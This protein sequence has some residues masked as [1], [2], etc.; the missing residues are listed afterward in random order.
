MCLLLYCRFKS[1]NAEKER[2]CLLFV[3]LF[4]S[5]PKPNVY[6][7]S[8]SLWEL[9]N[10]YPGKEL[11]FLLCVTIFLIH[12]TTLWEYLSQDSNSLHISVQAWRLPWI[13]LDAWISV[14]NTLDT[15]LFEQAR[16]SKSPWLR[17]L[18]LARPRDW[19]RP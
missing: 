14:E 12:C 7:F 8:V 4:K 11:Q 13:K 15:Q 18:L 3:N 17:C 9:S 16:F 1:F 5:T 2:I 10:Q 6:M 19:T